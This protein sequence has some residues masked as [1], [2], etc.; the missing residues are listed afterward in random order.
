MKT[1]AL[2]S[3]VLLSY[4]IARNSDRYLILHVWERQGLV[5]NP[6]QRKLFLRD[7]SSPETIRRMRQKFQ[8]QGLFEADKAVDQKRYEL[9]K[10]TKEDINFSPDTISLFDDHKLDERTRYDNA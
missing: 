8:E 5:L 7:V 1:K 9:Y 4:H 3:Q 10:E 2:V 6:E